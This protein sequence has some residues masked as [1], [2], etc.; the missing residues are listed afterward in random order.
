MPKRNIEKI[1]EKTTDL[2]Y[3]EQLKL[4]RS[5]QGKKWKLEKDTSSLTAEISTLSIY[6]HNYLNKKRQKLTPESIKKLSIS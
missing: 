2:S 1:T 3:E 6:N 4:Y 5:N